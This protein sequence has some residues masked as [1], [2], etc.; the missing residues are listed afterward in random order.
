MY[1]VDDD[2]DDAVD[3]DAM[4]TRFVSGDFG[5]FGKWA[6]VGEDNEKEA[7]DDGAEEDDDKDLVLYTAVNGGDGGAVLGLLLS[8]GTESQSSKNDLFLFML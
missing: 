8:L 6:L 5:D 1:D 7:N 3:V 4:F 2:D